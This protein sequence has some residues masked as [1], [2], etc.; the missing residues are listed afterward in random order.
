[1]LSGLT[2]VTESVVVK[3]GC[4]PGRRKCLFVYGHGRHRFKADRENT[5]EG[6]S[7][8]VDDILLVDDDRAAVCEAKSPSI[9]YKVGQ[10]L[11]QRGIELKWFRGQSLIPKN[12]AM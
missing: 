10:V 1:M 4:L 2:P 7:S 12:L 8:K 5:V 6:S 3:H 11:P 9:I